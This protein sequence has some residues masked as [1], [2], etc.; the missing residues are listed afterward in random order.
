MAESVTLTMQDN[1]PSQ[2]RW[3][4]HDY[5]VLDEP[6]LLDMD[7]GVMTHPLPA[8]AWRFTAAADDG[9]TRVFDVRYDRSSGQ[10]VMV[11]SYD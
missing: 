6:T 10:W 7:Y 3:N 2:M 4:A 9:D 5:R 11:R 1:R 8:A